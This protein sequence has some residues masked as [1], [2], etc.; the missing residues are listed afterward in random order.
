MLHLRHGSLRVDLLDPTS[1][2]SRLGPRFCAGGYVWQVHDDTVGPLL[3]G[4]EG[5]E[6]E[7]DPFNGHG[8][9]ESFRDRS[10]SGAPCSG[11]TPAPKR[12]LPAPALSS[13]ATAPSSSA[14]PASGTSR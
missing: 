5:P 8:L 1:E 7:P 4:P 10:R 9:P 2:A 12:S 13:A 3:S 14:S 11:T 6:P